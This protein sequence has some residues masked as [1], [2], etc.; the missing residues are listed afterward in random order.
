MPPQSIL[1]QCVS[2]YF[3]RG[4]DKCLDLGLTRCTTEE[5][6][7]FGPYFFSGENISPHR[8]GLYFLAEAH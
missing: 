2:D 3:I 7:I 5:Q 4:L 8:S 6:C 1:S